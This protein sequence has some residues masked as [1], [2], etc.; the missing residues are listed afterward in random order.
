[1]R[2]IKFKLYI[3]LLFKFILNHVGLMLY[4]VLSTPFCKP[5][6]LLKGRAAAQLIEALRYKPAGRGFDRNF[7]LT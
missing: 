5:L 7:S 1:M 4:S 3:L 6:N 2:V